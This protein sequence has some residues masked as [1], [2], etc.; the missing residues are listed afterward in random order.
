MGGHLR[1][2][3]KQTIFFF[4]YAAVEKVLFSEPYTHTNIF[5]HDN[6]FGITYFQMQTQELFMDIF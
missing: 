1:V 4:K 3:T 2:V 6:F 5:Y